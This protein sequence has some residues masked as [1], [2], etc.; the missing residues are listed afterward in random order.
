V[1]LVARVFAL[2]PAPLWPITWMIGVLGFLVEYVAW[3]V[4]LGAA[5]LSRSGRAARRTTRRSRRRPF[6]STRARAGSDRSEP[7]RT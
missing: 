5:L 2:V 6:L 3:S 1:T 7:L 4:G